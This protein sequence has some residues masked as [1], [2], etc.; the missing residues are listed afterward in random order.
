MPPH[1]DTRSAPDDPKQPAQQISPY[2][3]LASDKTTNETRKTSTLK[4]EDLPPHDSVD[5]EMAIQ[6]ILNKE[7]ARRIQRWEEEFVVQDFEP[8]DNILTTMQIQAEND[9]TTTS[10]NPAS[11]TPWLPYSL[12]WMINEQKR[13][14]DQKKY[15]THVKPEN[16]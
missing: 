9:T 11:T 7:V 3:Q 6:E 10:R 12:Q 15:V 5:T 8:N 1:G 14:E 16:I 2:R 4:I 13:I